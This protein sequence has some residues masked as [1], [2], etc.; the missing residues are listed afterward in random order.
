MLV[1]DIKERLRELQL[2]HVTREMH[3]SGWGCAPPAPTS[4]PSLRGQP[5]HVRG[6]PPKAGTPL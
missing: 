4:R 1:A 3:V 6:L 2:L 5:L